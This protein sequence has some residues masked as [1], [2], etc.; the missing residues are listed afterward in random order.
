MSKVTQKMQEG[1]KQLTLEAGEAFNIA[2]R[3]NRIYHPKK[4]QVELEIEEESHSKG[5]RGG[6]DCCELLLAHFGNP[7]LSLNVFVMGRVLGWT[8]PILFNFC[9]GIF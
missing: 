8:Y 7:T 9:F 1:R 4:K 2:T 5:R 6:E 3:R